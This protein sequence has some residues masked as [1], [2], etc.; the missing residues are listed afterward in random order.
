MH[1][2]CTQVYFILRLRF[3][4][5]FYTGKVLTKVGICQKREA[6]NSC[7]YYHSNH[8]YTLCNVI[9]N[10]CIVSTMLPTCWHSLRG[11]FPMCIALHVCNK[12]KVT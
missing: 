4:T 5:M 2:P 10:Y 6:H 12:N 8:V 7:E 1:N 11:T 3:N 9:H